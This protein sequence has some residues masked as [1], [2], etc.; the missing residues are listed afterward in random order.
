[1]PCQ[2]LV[3]L[4]EALLVRRIFFTPARLAAS[5]HQAL[6]HRQQHFAADLERGREQQIVRAADA[7]LG[8]ILDRHHAIAGLPRLH[9]P[10]YRVDRRARLQHGML[11]R[12]A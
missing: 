7:A 3:T 5:A 8:R 2:P 12:T 9:L 10:E 1:M 4:R 6:V 11:R